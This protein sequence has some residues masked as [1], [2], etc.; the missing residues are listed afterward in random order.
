M[1]PLLTDDAVADLPLHD[2]RA[3]LLAEIM[4]TPAPAGRRVPMAVAS[5]AAVAAAAAVVGLVVTLPGADAD[6]APDQATTGV[7]SSGP[8][9]PRPVTS[10]RGDLVSATDWTVVYT[11]V[12]ISELAQDGPSSDARTEGAATVRMRSD[13]TER[14]VV[15]RGRPAATYDA[16]VLR[17]RER[18]EGPTRS[19]TVLGRSGLRFQVDGR[20]VLVAPPLHDRWWQVESLD[21]TTAEL[22]ALARRA[23]EAS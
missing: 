19:A 20:T 11:R 16:A 14:D 22:L 10:L 4:R 5:A 17:L 9:E 13:E 15:L 23:R 21:A 8:A 3:A 18:A 12:A 2:A 1:N 6:R 7:A